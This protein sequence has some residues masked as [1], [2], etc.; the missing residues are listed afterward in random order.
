MHVMEWHIESAYSVSFEAIRL[1]MF[2]DAPPVP[3]YFAHCSF[4]KAVLVCFDGDGII[5][6]N[7]ALCC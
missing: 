5:R 4:I 7:S 3:F 6:G 1:E 2:R